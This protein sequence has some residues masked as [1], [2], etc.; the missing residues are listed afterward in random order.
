MGAVIKHVDPND[1]RT[2]LK[3]LTPKKDGGVI[4][5]FPQVNGEALAC[6]LHH[7]DNLP[8]YDF[9]GSPDF[10]VDLIDKEDH[11]IFQML[12]NEAAT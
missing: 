7:N 6:R 12:H 10:F 4:L 11:P 1:V 9:G 5:V 2:L 8:D 3:Y